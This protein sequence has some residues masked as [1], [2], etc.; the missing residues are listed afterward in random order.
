MTFV[1]RNRFTAIYFI[2]IYVS[3]IKVLMND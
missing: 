1:S 3:I 2:W